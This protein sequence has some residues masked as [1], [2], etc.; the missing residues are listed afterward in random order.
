MCEPCRQRDRDAAQIAVSAARI[1]RLLAERPSRVQWGA[2]TPSA[3][4]AGTER[5]TGT[6]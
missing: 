2:L 6:P 5:R 1:A 4:P 3:R